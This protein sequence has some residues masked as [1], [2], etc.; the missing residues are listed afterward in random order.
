MTE[1]KT[2]PTMLKKMIPHISKYISPSC[3]SQIHN[4]SDNI[5]AALNEGNFWTFEIPEDK[6]LSFEIK[7]DNHEPAEFIEISCKIK[8]MKNSGIIEQNITFTYFSKNNDLV[9]R[10]EWD[11]E[12]VKNRY[13]PKKGRVMLKFHFDKKCE[14]TRTPE[15]K[16]HFHVGGRSEKKECYWH[17]DKIELPRL[18]YPPLDIIIVCDIILMN[19]FPDYY[20]KLKAEN[21]DWFRL[22]K[23][24]QKLFQKEYMNKVIASIDN[25][26]DHKIY[27][28]N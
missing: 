27:A 1:I 8:G 15:P 9:Y 21:P 4:L 3:E 28:H 13:D 12:S 10:P 25:D 14:N 17:P 26:D 18:P 2:Y 24:S 20:E 11:S 16:Y 19:Y 7:K 5:K 6:R 23:K 22:V